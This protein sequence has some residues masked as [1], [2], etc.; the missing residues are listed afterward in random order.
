MVSVLPPNTS[1]NP[2]SQ[3]IMAHEAHRAR[4]RPVGQRTPM[5]KAGQR[6]WYRHDWGQPLTDAEVVRVDLD[7]KQDWNVW[8]YVLDETH[9]ERK[10][11]TDA[12]GQ[13]IMKMT[14]DPWPDVVLRTNYGIIVTRESRVEGS[15]GWLPRKTEA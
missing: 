2:T 7:N 5:P 10:P 9:P 4:C 12:L 13:R 6:V 3:P 14:E 11:V 8:C 1:L 15:P